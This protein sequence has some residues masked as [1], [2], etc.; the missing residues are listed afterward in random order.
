MKNKEDVGRWRNWQN[1]TLLIFKIITSFYL[2]NNK[3]RKYIKFG[4]EEGGE[5]R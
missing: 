5:N 4:E 2:I 1:Y 3:K